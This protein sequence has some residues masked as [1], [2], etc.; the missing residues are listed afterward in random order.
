MNRTAEPPDAAARLADLV[1]RRAAQ[2]AAD[3]AVEGVSDDLLVAFLTRYLGESDPDELAARSLDD[4]LGAALAHWT[5][6]RRR[7]PSTSLVQV[8]S[9]DRERDGW[10]S[11]HSALFVV[12]DDAPFLVDTIRMALDRVG[13]AAHLMIHP[14]LRVARD[15]DHRVTALPERGGHLEAWTMMEIDRCGP[16]TAERVEAEVRR[17]IADTHRAVGDFD[18][19]RTRMVE[20]AHDLEQLPPTGVPSEIVE[21]VVKLLG[22][23]ARRHFVFLGAATYDR[24]SDGTLIPLP[25]SALGLLTDDA[26]VDPAPAPH[27]RLLAISRADRP[28][29]VHRPARPT[30]IAVRRFDAAGRVQGEHR[31]IGLFSAAAYRES[32]L[33]IPYVRD[34]VAAVIDRSGFTADSHSGRSLRTVLETFPRD[35]LFEIGRDELYDVARGIVALQDRQIVRVFALPEAAGPWVTVLVH[36]PRS[37]YDARLQEVVAREVAEAFGGT[38]AGADSTVGASALAR[39]TVLVRVDDSDQDPVDIAAL[40]DRIDELSTPWSERVRDALVD[41]LGEAA[42]SA[43]TSPSPSLLRPPTERSSRQRVR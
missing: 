34:R 17:A 7:E 25:G 2:G 5:L 33:S 32:V 19:M 20:L 38:V 26:L 31:F 43:S 4:V 14:M 16:A 28:S 30:C 18:P 3:A 41:Q 37:R 24:A 13:V 42:G 22:W 6:G 27:D 36:L 23:L 9:P 39:I 8:L 29:T 12:T 10:S 11:E 15:G 21:A 35:D 40:E 1:R